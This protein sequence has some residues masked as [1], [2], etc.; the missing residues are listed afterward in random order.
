MIFLLNFLYF[1]ILYHAIIRI[2][3]KTL[4]GIVTVIAD[5]KGQLLEIIGIGQHELLV[6]LLVGI[7]VLVQLVAILIQHDH[8]KAAAGGIVIGHIEKECPIARGDILYFRS[9]RGLITDRIMA[10]GQAYQADAGKKK[11]EN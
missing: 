5:D 4:N 9:A 3:L 2:H 7:D 1:Y 11:G 6:E 8:T 10:V